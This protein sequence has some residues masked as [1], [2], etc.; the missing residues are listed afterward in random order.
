MSR[1]ELRYVGA[2]SLP[3]RLS[4]FELD[5]YFRLSR[6]DIAALNHNFRTNH[7]AGAA[8]FLLFLRNASRSLDL[9]VPVPRALLR[10]VGTVLGLSTP[11]LASLRAMYQRPQ[12][13]YAHQAWAK[14]YLG[15]KD[16]DQSVSDTLETYLNAHAEE[17]TSVDE[18]VTSA[19]HWLHQH[20]Y[21]IPGERAVRDLAFRCYS[22]AEQAIYR[23][24]TTVIERDALDRCREAVFKV[25]E[26][27]A[28]TVLDWLKTPPKGHGPTT[29]DETLDKISF[30]KELN[31]HTWPLDHVP[32]EKQ[33]GYAQQIQ[34]RRP[35]KSREIRS[36]AANIELVF[37]L[38]ITLFELTDSAMYQ[39]ARRVAGFV[40]NAYQKAQSAKAT[41]AIAYR[42]R[43]LSIRDI[44]QQQDRSA[45]ERLADIAA[46]LSDIGESPS[47]S[48]AAEM[49]AMLVNDASRVRTLL[50]ALD[51]VH[52][53]GTLSDP[54]LRNLAMLRELYNGRQ[55][56]LPEDPVVPVKSTW[57]PFVESTDR[58]RA[59]QALEVATIMELGKGLRRGTISIPHSLSYRE[60]DQLLI[61]PVEW[62]QERTRHLAILDLPD[63]S[64][65]FLVP[66][67]NTIKAGLVAVSEAMQDEKLHID[68]AGLLH[69]PRLEALPED[70]EP[71]KMIELMFRQIG[72]VQLPELMLEVD[73]HTN[74]SEILLG[75]RAYNEQELIALYAALIAHGT[76]IDAKGVASMTP[77]LDPVEVNMAMR[78]LETQGRLRSAND[79]IVDFQMRHD[80]ARHWGSGETA[81]SDMMSLDASRHLWN[82]R[83]DPRRRTHAVGI[84]THVHDRH[85]IIYDQPIVLNERQ[86]GAAIEGVVNY[87]DSTDRVRLQLLSVDTHGYTNVAMAI[88]KLLGFDLCPR[89]RNLS[90]RKLYLPRRMEGPTELKRALANEV[91][92][93]AIRKGWD[94]LL[95]LVASIR[96]GRVSATVALQRFGSAAQ[97]DPVHR[98]ADHLGK[99]LRTLYLCDYM[100]NVEFRREIHT[101]LNRGESVHQL[102]RAVYYGRVPPER[103]RRAN[104]MIAISGSH[105]LLTNLVIAWNT[106]KMQETVDRWHRAKQPVEETWL[107]RIGPAH[108]SHINFR[109]TFKF[110]VG[111][112]ADALLQPRTPPLRNSA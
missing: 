89:L 76:E 36:V 80:I 59:L 107:R 7:R 34:H 58:K 12:T 109:G 25:R 46:L 35:A 112:Y 99:L 91:S 20:Q 45:E 55:T 19:E 44:L 70:P 39:S 98:A 3:G 84:Y 51:S 43:C 108:F 27:N 21:L 63:D 71:R 30:L 78:T 67:L 82:A 8:V 15:L 56:E 69:L 14:G 111:R 81:S 87:N 13:L 10:H 38:R 1:Y 83:V 97:G 86:A 23:A 102:Q 65:T 24:I 6:T 26:G 37:F 9:S 79:R 103:G 95:R 94:Q 57:R 62:E 75:R 60:R 17:V 85:G 32:L 68:D 88:S 90:E 74:F 52:F 110:S 11:T 29:L 53:E 61:A 48:H 42:D 47:R 41:T 72:D 100:T 96:S 101:I 66:L 54:N 106:H 77:Q 2:T 31:V 92:L 93:T 104:E 5:Q 16:I 22:V 73:A 40:R 49:R 50:K 28:Y 18:L 33:R 4:D 64:H 105:V